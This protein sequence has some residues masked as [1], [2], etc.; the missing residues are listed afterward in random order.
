P[1]IPDE[2][3]PYQEFPLTGGREKW[4][5]PVG[6]VRW[7]PDPIAGNPGAFKA[8]TPLE[9][10]AFRVTIGMVA[11]AVQAPEGSLRLKNR[12]TAPSAITSEDLVWVEGKLRVDGDARLF[13]GKLDLRDPQG[14]DQGV[15]LS[16]RRAGDN[17][18][19]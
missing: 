2:S 12:T 1:L 7:R 13:G 16:L 19:G 17:Q 6:Q 18:A 10:N 5:I 11:G 14:Q 3:I 4:L 15:P 8:A 9:R